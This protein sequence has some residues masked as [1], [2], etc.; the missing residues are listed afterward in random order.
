MASMRKLQRRLRVW[1]RYAS[2]YNRPDPSSLARPPVKPARG[3]T[4]ALIRL[5][6]EQVR[7][8]WWDDRRD[9]TCN[10]CVGMG[11]CDDGD[12]DDDLTDDADDDWGDDGE[13]WPPGVIVEH[14]FA[15]RGLL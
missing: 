4:R 6:D 3:H 7:R 9:C 15:E 12:W 14:A 10:G 8:G 13:P 1:Q 2:R 11:P 5:T